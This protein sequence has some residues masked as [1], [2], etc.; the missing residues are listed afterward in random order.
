MKKEIIDEIKK[1]IKDEIKKD[2]HDEIRIEIEAEIVEKEF[3]LEKIIQRNLQYQRNTKVVITGIPND[4][5][6]DSLEHII[7][8]SFNKVYLQQITSRDIAVVH[9]ISTNNI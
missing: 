5:N 7:I 8:E 4:V 1:D 3:D 6:H 2:I 9:G